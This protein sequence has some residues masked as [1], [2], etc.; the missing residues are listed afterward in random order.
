MTAIEKIFKQLNEECLEYLHFKSSIRLAQS[1]AGE[2][3]FDI[4]ISEGSKQRIIHI[5]NS[6]GARRRYATAN[7]RFLGVSDYL[8]FDYK[9]GRVY[10]FHL[11]E[12]LIFG[13]KL[14]KSYCLGTYGDFRDCIVR[15]QAFGI[16]RLAYDVEQALFVLRVVCKINKARPYFL[17]KYI[18]REL[19]LKQDWLDELSWLQEVANEVRAQSPVDQYRKEISQFQNAIK[20]NDRTL[21]EAKKRQLI[22]KLNGLKYYSGWKL[23]LAMTNR[24]AHT[25]RPVRWLKAYD[26]LPIAVIGADGSGKTTLC[27]HLQTF[28]EKKLTCRRIYLGAPK[29]FAWRAG[30]KFAQIVQEFDARNGKGPENFFW[31][32]VA[33]SRFLKVKRG[34]YASARNEIVIFERFPME[35]FSGMDDPMD[36]PRVTSDSIFFSLEN[37]VYR[38]IYG[39]DVKKIILTASVDEVIERK[40]TNASDEE[41]SVVQRKVR[42]VN[43]LA[44]DSER[45]I[46]V[47]AGN[48][49]EDVLAHSL[50]VILARGSAG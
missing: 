27:N 13:G 18:K 40:F 39:V 16:N 19:P 46:T 23:W 33:I 2:T 49:T 38:V 10:H 5:L 43:S 41:I 26:N 50:E 22:R 14:T 28:L 42:A 44:A 25:L 36:G 20:N 47:D 4:L 31:V 3:D 8:V 1:F 17:R 15:D 21:F 34:I 12:R 32:C 6:F 35:G 9:P 48:S 45:V 30:Y 24:F 11:H 37:R 29:G 7:A